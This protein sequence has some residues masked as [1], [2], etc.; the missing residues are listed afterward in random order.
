MC[1]TA[2][3]VDSNNLE[4]APLTFQRAAVD[5]ENARV[6]VMQLLES[7]GDASLSELSQTS[8]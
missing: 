2:K 1:P 6:N 5:A 4:K 7:H 3:L 8:C